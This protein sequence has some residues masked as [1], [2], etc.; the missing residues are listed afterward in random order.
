MCMYTHIV[1]VEDDPDDRDFFLEELW[2]VNPRISCKWTESGFTA[3]QLLEKLPPRTTLIF[4]D[5][6]MPLMS[7]MEFLKLMR[8]QER[9][10]NMPVVVLTTS[11]EHQVPC[12]KSGAN[13]YVTKPDSVDRFHYVLSVILNNDI[14]KD[15]DFV[16]NLLAN[17]KRLQR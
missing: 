16:Q 5:L 14:M 6:N 2:N 15:A 7:G 10:R 1:L 3:L 9:F 17:G 12:K 13:L 8:E 4:L 11:K